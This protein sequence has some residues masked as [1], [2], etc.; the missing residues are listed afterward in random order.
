MSIRTSIQL[1]IIVLIAALAL[2]AVALVSAQTLRPST[3]P[4]SAQST[5]GSKKLVPDDGPDH[6]AQ[7]PDEPNSKDDQLISLLKEQNKRLKAK[8]ERLEKENAE[9]KAKLAEKQ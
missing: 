5:F 2:C 6:S 3:Q 4:S 7:V 8:V 9:L 1:S